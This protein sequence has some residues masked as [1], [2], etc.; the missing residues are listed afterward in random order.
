MIDIK[1]TVRDFEKGI[2][3][4]LVCH[5]VP[6]LG[7]YTL[8]VNY[9]DGTNDTIKVKDDNRPKVYKSLDSVKK[10]ADKVGVKQITLLL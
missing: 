2:A 7:G 9:F 5:S 8:E 10:D 6:V 1:T 4:S 3:K